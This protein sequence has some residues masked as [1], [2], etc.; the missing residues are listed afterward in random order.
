MTRLGARMVL[1]V[2]VVAGACASSKDDAAAP[3]SSSTARPASSTSSS[4]GPAVSCR[5]VGEAPAGGA[6]TWVTD[7]R[8]VDAGG[9]L[10]APAE[11]TGD[12]EWGGKADR[13]LI[14]GGVALGSPPATMPL[15]PGPLVLSKP[16]GTA[17]LR[18][19]KDGTLEKR[20][21]DSQ[22]WTD[23]S[24]LA[25]HE[26][27]V[28]HPA[29]RS[30]VSSGTDDEG[31]ATLVIA[32]NEGR[33]PRPL[34]DDES[35]EHVADPV[36]TASGA[37]LF[38]AD[39][40]DHVDLHRLEIDAGKLTTVTSVKAPATIANITTSPFKGGGVAWTTGDCASKTPPALIAERGG[41][42][43]SLS[44]TKAATAR[45][46]GWLPDGRLVAVDGQIC[47]PA[48]PGKLLVVNDGTADVVAEGV[49]TAAIRA[50]RP[51]PPPP[52]STI[53]QRAPA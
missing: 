35:A 43:L 52:P 4:T 50:V 22:E 17:V 23:I 3:A 47:K 15:G 29:G 31:N 10:L 44:D 25:G 32:D 34:L 42:Y 46:V 2:L 8:L 18:V 48:V 53:S 45:P 28:Y 12:V 38:T 37:L 41:N 26:T 51:P 19:T 5:G 9:C 14:G 24:F 40:G 27:A 49:S 1:A 7:G 21:L 11:A 16:V 33:D 6:V 20:K 13:V 36:F 39:H 30:I